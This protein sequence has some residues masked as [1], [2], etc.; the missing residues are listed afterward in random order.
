[1]MQESTYYLDKKNNL[2][3]ILIL[4]G[5]GFVRV[6]PHKMLDIVMSIECFEENFI[7]I[8]K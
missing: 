6:K 7:K 5:N 4:I 1:M 3:V 8:T 2:I